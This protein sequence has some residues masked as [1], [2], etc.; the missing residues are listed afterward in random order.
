M[1]GLGLSEEQVE[2]VMTL[3]GTSMQDFIP[4]SELQEKIDAAIAD[5]KSKTPAVDVKESEE[6]KA[7]A[8]EYESFKRKTES[9]SK[10]LKGGVKEKFVDNVF[11]MLDPEKPAEEQLERIR[12][13]YE[14]YFSQQ[15]E[16]QPKPQFGTEVKGTMP[17]GSKATTFG[18]V[19]GFGKKQ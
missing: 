8:G 4:K 15:P 18:D 6:Y 1:A 7:L 2:K 19:W 17:Q 9:T 14:E 12:G 3:H 13:E 5:E 10:L 11:S 16:P